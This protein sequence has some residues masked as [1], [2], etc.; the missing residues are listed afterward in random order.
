MRAAALIPVCLLLFTA[1]YCRAQSEDSLLILQHK[2]MVAELDSLHADYLRACQAASAVDFVN[3]DQRA[4]KLIGH[5]QALGVTDTH[6][7]D[8]NQ[9]KR[10]IW[11]NFDFDK[12]G[13]LGMDVGHYSDAIDYGGYLLRVADSLDSH[14]PLRNYTLYAEIWAETG[15]DAW[16]GAP[17]IDLAYQYEREFPQGPFI[18]QVLEM[19]GN[20]NTDLYHHLVCEKKGDD[21]YHD[22]TPSSCP[23]QPLDVQIAAARQEALK[24]WQRLKVR[25]PSRRAEFNEEIGSLTEDAVSSWHYCAD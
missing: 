15:E 20:C 1:P 5:Y 14:S 10:K 19:I 22:C 6:R 23:D 8:E 2:Q 7:Y 18:E 24:Y 17:D 25:Y 4:R 3:L 12:V 11:E 16:W 21:D 13:D 9:E